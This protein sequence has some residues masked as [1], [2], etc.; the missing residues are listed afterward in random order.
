M[1]A[2]IYSAVAMYLGDLPC[3]LRHQRLRLLQLQD[4]PQHRG[5]VPLRGLAQHRRTSAD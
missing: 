3:L 4:P 1:L 2:L 5:L